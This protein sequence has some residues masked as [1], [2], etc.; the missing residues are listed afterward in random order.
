M[1]AGLKL[2]ERRLGLEKAD[3]VEIHLIT[4]EFAEKFYAS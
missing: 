4:A 2:G 3:M 1:T